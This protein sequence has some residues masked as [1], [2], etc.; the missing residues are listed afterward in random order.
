MLVRKRN[1]KALLEKKSLYAI[2]IFTCGNGRVE[3]RYTLQGFPIEHLT[4]LAEEFCS[5]LI[6]RVWQ[7]LGI[8]FLEAQ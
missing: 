4:S 1:Y 8:V 6:S 5:H 3:K 2:E 7:W